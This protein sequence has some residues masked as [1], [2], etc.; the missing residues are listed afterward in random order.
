MRLEVG[1]SK[2]GGGEDVWC[3]S[4]GG[5]RTCGAG[6]AAACCVGVGVRD[7]GR[8]AARVE[9]MSLFYCIFFYLFIIYATIVVVGHLDFG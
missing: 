3:G 1:V 7:R 2:S 5:V 8:G 6:A 9:R 4:G